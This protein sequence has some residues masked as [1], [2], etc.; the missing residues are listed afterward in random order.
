TY[1]SNV[2]IIVSLAPFFTVL[3]ARIFLKINRP[4]KNFIMG[5]ILAMAGIIVISANPDELEFNIIGDGLALLAALAWGFYSIFTRKLADYGL[6]SLLA[7]RAVFFYGL[8]FMLPATLFLPLNLS[9]EKLSTPVN[10]INIL[11]LGLGASAI[12]FATWTFA[13]K[14]LGVARSSMYI[15]LVPPVTVIA[16]YFVLGEPINVKIIAGIVLTIGGLVY[17]E[18]GKENK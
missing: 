10:L 1:A 15:Y 7:T 13:I 8:L 2:A 16:A 4:G 12:C 17:A 11:F 9:L 6:E 18:R 5:F 14:L 3:L